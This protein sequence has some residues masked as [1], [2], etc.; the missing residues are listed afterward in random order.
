MPMPAREK[1]T[2]QEEYID[3][4]KDELLDPAQFNVP[5]CAEGGPDATPG[6][7]QSDPTGL[8]K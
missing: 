4:H 7:I 1:S 8:L 6:T 5:A 2:L 3:D